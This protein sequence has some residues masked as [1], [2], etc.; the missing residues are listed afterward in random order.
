MKAYRDIFGN[1]L[2][3]RDVAAAA[4]LLVKSSSTAPTLLQRSFGWGYGKCSRVLQLL[5]DAAVVG[6]V[7]P[8]GR[9]LILRNEDEAVNAAL[10]Q[11]RKGRVPA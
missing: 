1:E 5:E 7:K 11:L 3:K 9:T 10:R 4:R 8:T 2:T 6:P